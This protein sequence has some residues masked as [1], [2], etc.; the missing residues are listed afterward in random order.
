MG[1]VNGRP[2]P[3]QTQQAIDEH[4][5]LGSA[6]RAMKGV[7]LSTGTEKGGTGGSPNATS[8]NLTPSAPNDSN[9]RFKNSFG[10][11][12]SARQDNSSFLTGI[13]SSLNRNQKKKSTLG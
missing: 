3:D 4:G 8:G 6:V 2:A 10:S 5:L 11:L 1:V 7:G 9:T 12:G 13:N